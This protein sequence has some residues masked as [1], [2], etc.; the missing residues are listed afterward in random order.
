LPT[1]QHQLVAEFLDSTGRPVLSREVSLNILA[2]TRDTVLF[3]SDR[4]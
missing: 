3:I 4:P 1:G 2:G